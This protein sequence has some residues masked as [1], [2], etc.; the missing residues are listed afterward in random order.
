MKT[1]RSRPLALAALG[2]LATLLVLAA[3][4]GAHGGEGEAEIT[5]ITR[6]GD[7]V[8]VVAHVRYIEDG[9]GV[10]DATVTVV[11]DDGTPVPMEAG[12]EEGDYTATVAA[13]PGAAIRVTS[14]EPATTAEGTAPAAADDPATT[15]AS[16]GS[17]PTTTATTDA[18][19][20]DDTTD[21]GA[22]SADEGSADGGEDGATAPSPAS[23][24]EGSDDGISPVVIGAIVAVVLAAVVTGAILL[25]KKPTDDARS[26]S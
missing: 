1:P 13:G 10:P 26:G 16:T 4:A 21:D 12:A 7:Q 20:T 17:D 14:V 11:V 24:D 25:T 18:G 15:E 2:V 5:S 3:P 19:T 9:H 22:G 8:T 23:D 6:D